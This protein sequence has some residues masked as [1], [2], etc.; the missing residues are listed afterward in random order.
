VKGSMEMLILILHHCQRALTAVMGARMYKGTLLSVNRASISACWATYGKLPMY[1]RGVVSA[2]T[3][4]WEEE[5]KDEHGLISRK[6]PAEAI[7]LFHKHAIQN[8]FFRRGTAQPKV[9]GIF[10]QP[11]WGRRRRAGHAYHPFPLNISKISMT[12]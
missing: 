1:S 10:L 9:M 7:G 11:A 12:S 2:M 4:R 5:A 6:T 3:L 8:I